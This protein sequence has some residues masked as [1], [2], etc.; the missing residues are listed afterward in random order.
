MILFLLKLFIITFFFV[1][2]I[3]L[4]CEMNIDECLTPDICGNGICID[5][6]GSYRCEC[7]D[8]GKCGFNCALD[9]PCISNPCV[10][11]ICESKCAQQSDYLCQCPEEF[12]GKNC[13]E[14]AVS[15]LLFAFY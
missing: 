10:K 12:A 1:G 4:L 2:Y 9:N 7:M 8:K 6:Q 3:G 5:T 13:S 14:P 15:F 11:G